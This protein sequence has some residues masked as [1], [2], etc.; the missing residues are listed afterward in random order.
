[1]ACFLVLLT[2]S[3]L[4]LKK[5]FQRAQFLGPHVWST[6]SAT[7]YWHRLPLGALNAT[8]GDWGQT[9]RILTFGTT[10]RVQCHR[11]VEWS[12]PVSRR[13]V[14]WWRLTYAVDQ[15][16]KKVKIR[17]ENAPRKASL[18]YRV[19]LPFFIPVCGFFHGAKLQNIKEA[20][21]WLLWGVWLDWTL[22]LDFNSSEKKCM[23]LRSEWPGS[24]PA[25]LFLC[26]LQ[27]VMPASSLPPVGWGW[28]GVNVPSLKGWL[29]SFPNT[30]TC[31]ALGTW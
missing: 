6:I 31:R 17:R 16:E 23:A 9:R 29:L 22:Q 28:R 24:G 4:L 26:N 14:I 25:S 7:C 13:E 30:Y 20:M 18:E 11:S 1:M 19:Q 12:S 5:W 3:F 8:V 15:E 27:P 10:G 2:S 21:A